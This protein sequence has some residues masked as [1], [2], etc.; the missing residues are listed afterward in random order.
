MTETA[1]ERL[2]AHPADQRTM[3]AVAHG[4][5]IADGEAT[6]CAGCQA[7][8]RPPARVTLEVERSDVIGGYS[9]GR[10]WCATCAP[11]A[12]V[13]RTDG[14]EQ[15]LVEA[16]LALTTHEQTAVV[17]PVETTTIDYSPALGRGAKR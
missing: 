17:V 5:P 9:V 13:E 3:A 16:R 4:Q 11:D 15:A 8:L 2:R 1:T 7:D 14:V 12:L 10:T 6:Y